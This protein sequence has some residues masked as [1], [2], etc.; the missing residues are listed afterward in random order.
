MSKKG[1]KKENN[2]ELEAQKKKNE[3]LEKENAKLKEQSG[4]SEETKTLIS[5]LK[6]QALANALQSA[7]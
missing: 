5:N 6:H 1:G 4:D 3:Q 2:A 7:I